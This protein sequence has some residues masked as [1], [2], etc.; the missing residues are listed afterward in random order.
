ML[1]NVNVYLYK[2]PPYQ[3]SIYLSLNQNGPPVLICN[4]VIIQCR[5]ILTTASCIHYQTTVE[6]AAE[7]FQANKISVIAGTTSEFAS[8]LTVHVLDIIIA[9]SFNATTH[10]NDLAIL[11][12][13]SNLPLGLRNDLK[14]VILDDIDNVDKPCLTL[15]N[16]LSYTR[17]EQLEFLSNAE[18]QDRSQYPLTRENDICSFYVLPC[19]FHC[20]AFDD[21]A[22]NNVD[23]GTG[24]LCKNHLV[25]LLSTILP[26]PNANDLNCSQKVVRNYYTNLENHLTWI[27]SVI[28]N[29]ELQVLKE[30]TF[31][32]SSPYDGFIENH[33][34]LL[35]EAIEMCNGGHS[36]QAT[37]YIDWLS[38]IYGILATLYY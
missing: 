6:S 16:I 27:Y 28:H 1:Y 2:Q 17:T 9:K 23:R 22:R 36:A 21:F 38:L 3:V 4:G 13:N 31:T 24:L 10:D 29:E 7:P 12:L 25:G 37:L 14:W 15:N 11:R 19:G 35:N 5:L 34:L 30:G 18:C 20:A 33:P 26:L 32:A 8:E